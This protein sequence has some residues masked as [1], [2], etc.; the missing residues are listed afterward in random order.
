MH[1]NSVNA[2]QEVWGSE[3]REWRPPWSSWWLSPCPAFLIVGQALSL[4]S[5]RQVRGYSRPVGRYTAKEA[6]GRD[7]WAQ[8]VTCMLPG[9]SSRQ[10]PPRDSP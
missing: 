8:G 4:H 7:A 2:K 3:E 1:K 5:G 9:C 6:R 10:V